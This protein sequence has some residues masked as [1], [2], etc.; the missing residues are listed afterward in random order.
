MYGVYHGGHGSN[1]YMQNTNNSD[2]ART[3]KQLAAQMGMS[4]DTLENYKILADM[5]QELDE[6]V[7][8][9]VVI[10]EC[11]AYFVLILWCAYDF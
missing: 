2:S 1:Q 7:N 11:A 10:D 6:L 8:T 9:G 3:Q 5:I 4:V